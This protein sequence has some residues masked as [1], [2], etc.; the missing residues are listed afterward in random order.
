[1]FRERRT[2]PLQRNILLL[3]SA[4]LVVMQPP[5]R[6][7]ASLPWRTSLQKMSDRRESWTAVGL[8]QTDKQAASARKP[9]FTHCNRARAGLT[10]AAH[11][12]KVENE[13]KGR[14]EFPGGGAER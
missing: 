11:V 9:V 14:E 4:N 12:H 2:F 1:M 10:E 7:S 8:F 6:S 13:Q 3:L 5:S